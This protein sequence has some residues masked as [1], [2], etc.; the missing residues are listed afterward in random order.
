MSSLSLVTI[1]DEKAFSLSERSRL[2]GPYLDLRSIRNCATFSDPRVGEGFISTSLVK[3]S[4]A[5]IRYRFPFLSVFSNTTK[6]Y[7]TSMKGLELTNECLDLIR[8]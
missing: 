3:L 1:R 4:T 7:D 6:S 5:T 8:S 2:M